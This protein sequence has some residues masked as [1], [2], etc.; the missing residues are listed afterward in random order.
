[1]TRTALISGAGRGIGAATARELGRRGYHVIVNYLAN[2]AAAQR[3]VA[4]I[5]A[6]GGTAEAIQADVTDADQVADLV[7]RF[8]TLDVLIC[9]A[10]TVMP[11]FEPFEALSWDAF[12]GKIN[13]ELAG[14]YHLTQR[15]LPLMRAQRSGRIVYV[16]STAA[17]HVGTV[18]AHSI[19][20]SALNL[21]SQHVAADAGRHG[22]T[23]N[24]VAAGAVRTDATADVFNGSLLTYLSDRSVSGRILEPEDIAQV[25]VTLA[26][27]GV[28]VTGQIVR[29][30][31]GH[32]VLDQQLGGFAANLGDGS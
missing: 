17:D 23:V 18:M 20:K 31:G 15:V 22:I 16:S 14:A 21:F 7:G 11:P 2:K 3:V 30:D 32:G 8:T 10:N 29:A 6:D 4:D 1:M 9:N 12:A 5:E 25:I 13:G 19:A 26:E 24:T 27:P 28:A